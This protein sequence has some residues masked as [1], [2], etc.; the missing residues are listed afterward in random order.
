MEGVESYMALDDQHIHT[1]LYQICKREYQQ[2]YYLI[3]IL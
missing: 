1:K 3:N 2:L